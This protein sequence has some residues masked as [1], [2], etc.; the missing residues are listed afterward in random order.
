VKAYLQVQWGEFCPFCT[1]MR[2]NSSKNQYVFMVGSLPFLPKF[3]QNVYKWN[4]HQKFTSLA[5]STNKIESTLNLHRVDWSF[6]EQC[7]L[8]AHAG[9]VG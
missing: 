2:L 5:M 6:S 8:L 1:S 4:H 3:N 7:R 9:L